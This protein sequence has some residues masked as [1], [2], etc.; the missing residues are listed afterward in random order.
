MT[1]PPP[2]RPTPSRPSSVAIRQGQL[3]HTLAKF[4][5]KGLY[6]AAEFLASKRLRADSTA[7][8]YSFALDY[9][10]DYLERR[11]SSKYNIQTAL[12]GL[13][14]QKL[15]V[16]RLLSGYVSYL[17]DETKNGHDLSGKTVKM[18]MTAVKSY[19]Q[20][21]GADISAVKFKHQI[22]MPPIYAEGEEPIDANDIRE[23]LNHCSNRRL[24]AYIL[25]LASG[26]M[27]AIEALAI[28]LRDINFDSGSPTEI[29][30]RKEYTKTRTER[31]AFISDEATEYL[32]Q[33]IDWKYTVRAKHRPK[34]KNQDDLVFSRNLNTTNNPRGFYYKVL[35]EFQKVLELCDGLSSRKEDGVQKRRKI[36]F[37]SFRRFCKTTI[38]NQTSTDFSEWFLGHKSS[39][40]YRVKREDQRKLYKENCMRYL[41]F[42]DYPTVQATGANY[43][44]KL[45]EKEQEIEALKQR[46]KDSEERMTKLEQKVDHLMNELLEANNYIVGKKQK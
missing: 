32:K 6:L 46:G 5:S 38:A 11:Y 37:H 29:K 19:L 36:T 21:N 2:P 22:T 45:K 34:V 35:V 7:K 23:M 4:K 27:R 24:K 17:K 20:Y 12:D 31:T 8:A 26:G 16:Y 41:T 15:D 42:L 18:Y 28:R 10:N 9:F 43:E 13:K 3:D 39:P 14:R 1:P 25:V 40:Y 30:I 33:W 44:A